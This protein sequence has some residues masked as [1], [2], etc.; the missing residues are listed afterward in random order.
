MHWLFDYDLTLYGHEERFV[1]SALERNISR[2]LMDR[3]SMLEGDANRL[4]QSR[5][6]LLNVT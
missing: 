6:S 5:I 4:R 1:I 3:F 2:F